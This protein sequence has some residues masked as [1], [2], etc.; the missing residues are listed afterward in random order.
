MQELL[1]ITF[2]ALPDHVW[3]PLVALGEFCKNFCA[4]VL[5][6]DLLMEMHRNI[7]VILYKLEII[8]PPKFWNVMEHLPVHLAQ[9]AH[10]G[11]PIHY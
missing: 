9:E 7:A 10:L 3:K 2:S 4:N 1:P 11:D 6:E 8:F 5:H